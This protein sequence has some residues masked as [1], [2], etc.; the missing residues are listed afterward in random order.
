VVT[1]TSFPDAPKMIDLDFFCELKR[2]PKILSQRNHIAGIPDNEHVPH[3]GLRK[4]G[5]KD[6]N[7][8]N[9]NIL[10]TNKLK[11]KMTSNPCT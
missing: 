10:L 6:S 8:G 11:I 5:G 4:A 9:G 3:L 1:E 2:I 7:H